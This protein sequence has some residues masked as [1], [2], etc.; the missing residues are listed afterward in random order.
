MIL[1]YLIKII[2]LK[3]DLIQKYYKLEDSIY[4]SN[5]S[6]NVISIKNETKSMS[7]LAIKSLV[8][9]ENSIL[10]NEIEIINLNHR[11]DSEIRFE[12]SSE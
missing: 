1:I 6:S 3:R 5:S 12:D 10:Q 4:S 9:V 8:K 11:L 2:H 7:N